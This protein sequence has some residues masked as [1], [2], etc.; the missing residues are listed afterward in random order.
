MVTDEFLLADPLLEEVRIAVLD[1]GRFNVVDVQHKFRVGYRRALK[2]R[3]TLIAEG[4]VD[5]E[6]ID[7]QNCL[8]G[9]LVI[10]EE[11]ESKEA[12][13]S[14]AVG[15]VGPGGV[16]DFE[17]LVNLMV[18]DRPAVLRLV[19]MAG[20]KSLLNTFDNHLQR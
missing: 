10:Q 2:F 8:A 5:P 13:L 4:I 19:I 18:V 11:Q 6:E 15:L 9:S 17:R 16:K 3:E 12:A 20:I 14:R 7:G 1:A